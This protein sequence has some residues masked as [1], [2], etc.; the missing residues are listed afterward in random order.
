MH[1]RGRIMKTSIRRP[2]IGVIGMALPGYYLGDEMC[3]DKLGEMLCLLKKQEFEVIPASKA[4]FS[5]DDTR[6]IGIEFACKD[7]DCIVAVITTFV[8]DYYIT[9]LLSKCRKPVFLWVVDREL[10]CIPLVCGALITASLYNLKH[11]YEISADDIGDNYT[12]E[13]LRIFAKAAML[14]NILKSAKIG[15]IG[16]RASTMMSQSVDELTL[17][18]K[19]GARVISIPTEEFYAAANSIDKKDKQAWLSS[20]NQQVDCS[21]VNKEDADESCGY[22]LG[23]KSLI[24]KYDLDA[25]CLNCFPN[26]KAK[27]CLAVAK[28]N[29]DLYASGC[30]GD[31]LAT[32]LM[33]MVEKFTGKAAFNGDFLR[34]F[35]GENS[36]V[37]SHCGAGGFSLAGDIKDINLGKSIETNDGVGVFYETAMKGK[38]TLLNLVANREELRLT[39]ISGESMKDNSGYIGNPLRIKFETSIENLYKNICKHGAGVHWV[40]I[41]GDY[42]K[43]F[44]LWCSFTGIK[45]NLIEE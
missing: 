19:T 39:V 38:V 29:D 45:F 6:E 4:A 23:C 9:E 40:A 24:N 43:V 18:Q 44:E 12:L 35:S 10:H 16:G 21:N 17:V 8:A 27:V 41:E 25:L 7:I 15:F 30:E 2:K 32:I 13:R 14:N 20:L 42:I 28:M 5:Q 1:N 37:F 34:M 33:Y 22:Y 3:E 11:D 36:A 31:I 26:L